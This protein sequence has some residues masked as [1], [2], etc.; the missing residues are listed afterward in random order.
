MPVTLHG[1]NLTR[2][3]IIGSGNIGPDIAFFFSRA[4]AAHGVQIVVNDISKAALEAG[5]ERILRKLKRSTESGSFK[6]ADAAAFEKNVVFTLDKS[7]LTGA[8][9]AI[10]A[11]T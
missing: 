1:R 5:R 2:V 4:L 9:L 3:A 8:E 11:A 7:L 6:P 10:E